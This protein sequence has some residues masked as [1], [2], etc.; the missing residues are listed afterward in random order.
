MRKRDRIVDLRFLP[1]LTPVIYKRKQISQTFFRVTRGATKV[2]K[3][4]GM[5]ECLFEWCD[6]HAFRRSTAPDQGWSARFALVSK[7]WQIH[8]YIWVCTYQARR[9]Y[10]P[11]LPGMYVLISFHVGK[12]CA[13]LRYKVLRLPKAVSSHLQLLNYNGRYLLE[14][15]VLYCTTHCK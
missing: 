11:G 10:L 13:S 9:K 7:P 8:T 2:T 12:E 4:V 14:L 3:A 6:K 15:Y 5:S 1:S